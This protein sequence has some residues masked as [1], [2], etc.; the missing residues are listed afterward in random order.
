MG[1]LVNNT[2]SLINRKGSTGQFP[3]GVSHIKPG[4]VQSAFHA[5]RFWICAINQ[6]QI[7]S[8]WEKKKIPESPK[9]QNLNLPCSGNYLHS[10]YIVVGITGN[11]E[12]I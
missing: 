6:L 4:E 5:R 10:I 7:E 1:A 9:K 8:I 2:G 11:L 3:L 12:M